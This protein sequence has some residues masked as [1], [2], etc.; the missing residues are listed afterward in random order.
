M[1]GT[2]DYRDPQ[3][4]REQVSVLRDLCGQLKG[5]KVRLMEVC[6]TH[7][8][9]VY[10][11]GIRSLLPPEINLLSG[12][13]CPVCV[14]PTSWID[15]TIVLARMPKVILAT[16]GDLLKVPGSQENLAQAKAAGAE[17]HVVYSPLDALELA[18][19]QPDREVVFPG[20]GFE[21][22]V[23][24][25]AATVLM[26]EQQQIPNFS[27]LSAH[28]VMPPAM[29][30]LATAPDLRVDG[31]LCPG[32][33]AAITG[34]R[35]FGF[36]AH[37]YH[38]PCVIAGFEAGDVLTG[39]ILLVRQLIAGRAEV[40]NQYTRIVTR[41]GNHKAQVIVEQMMEPC[42]TEWR[43]FGIIPG[44]G[45]KLRSAYKHRDAL[46]RFGLTLPESH[47][48]PGC[49][50]GEVLRGAKVPTECSLFGKACTPEKPVG[51]CMVSQEGTC[52]AW[53][54]YGQTS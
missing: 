31:F 46:T 28:K 53:F 6:G 33:V 50:C 40:E 39:L 27:I 45:L 30:A 43:G 21:T 2:G 11:H 32:H 54:R 1:T 34:Y 52:A 10:R 41:E 14:T 4:V 19:T 29:E 3:W 20:I 23:P 17:V 44:S 49:L 48:T 8:M 37:D 42:D 16:F 38:K 24:A 12:P 15:V 7:T 25:V 13:G 22:T 18:R 5:R 26:A 47:P 35:I 51:A 36:L 9:S